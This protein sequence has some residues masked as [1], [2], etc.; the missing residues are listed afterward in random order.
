MIFDW[1]P[2]E[3]SQTR[4]TEALVQDLD[5]D[6]GSGNQIAAPRRRFYGR[7]RTDVSLCLQ[8]GLVAPYDAGSDR[9]FQKLTFYFPSW[10]LTM[11]QVGVIST[12]FGVVTLL[13][14]LGGSGFSAEAILAPIFLL[15][16]LALFLLDRKNKSA[17]KQGPLVSDHTGRQHQ[18]FTAGINHNI[19][20]LMHDVSDAALEY[21]DPLWNLYEQV[22]EIADEAFTAQ[23]KEQA[24]IYNVAI[25]EQ[26]E[27]I[28]GIITD[29]QAEEERKLADTEQ[30]RI[31]AHED[32]HAISRPHVDEM[33]EGLRARLDALTQGIKH[34]RTETS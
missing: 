29:R 24:T 5:S 19:S 31:L 20:G 22:V 12:V 34:F 26:V 25:A 16:S 21:S 15:I 30:A 14:A 17:Q 2:Q 18:Q 13:V 7:T 33:N 10:K 32:L 28:R 8:D 1:I 23:S 9:F 3:S 27:Q 6:V 4:F 11:T